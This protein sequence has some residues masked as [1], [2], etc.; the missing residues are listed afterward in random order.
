MLDNSGIKVFSVVEP[1]FDLRLHF[2]VDR[3]DNLVEL[4]A[5]VPFDG[6][7]VANESSSK[8]SN[9]SNKLSIICKNFVDFFKHHFDFLV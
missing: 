3:T 6:K 4:F 7:I 8:K 2:E 5:P 9:D 1:R